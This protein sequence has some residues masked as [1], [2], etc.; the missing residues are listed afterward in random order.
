M[1]EPP[2][3]SVVSVECDLDVVPGGQEIGIGCRNI[4]PRAEARPT[5]GADCQERLGDWD[6]PM[7][8]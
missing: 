4:R 5:G 6:G 8:V 3:A 1:S 2:C 7:A